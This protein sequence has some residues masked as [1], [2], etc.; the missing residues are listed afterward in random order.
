MRE[1]TGHLLGT[2]Q[3]PYCLPHFPRLSKSESKL[4]T[5]LCF[6]TSYSDISL[7]LLIIG[8]LISFSE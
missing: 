7:A 1:E 3:L 5:F 4:E 6:Y 2:L 8:E